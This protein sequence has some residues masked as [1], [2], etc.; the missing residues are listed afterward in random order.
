[1]IASTSGPSFLN[2]QNHVI[3]Y[4]EISVG[5][6]SASIVDPKAV[7]R[8]ALLAGAVHVILTHNHPSTDV[9]PSKED[10][11]LTQQLVRGARLLNLTIHDH[12][13]IEHGTKWTSLAAKGLV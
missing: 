11:A 9:T 8:A 4:H 2:T 5:S 10:I 1:M 6:V 7:F 3:R 12:V 13:I